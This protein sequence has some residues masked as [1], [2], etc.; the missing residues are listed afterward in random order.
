ML[1][2]EE[3][4]QKYIYSLQVRASS[5]NSNKSNNYSQQFLKLYYLTFMC[6]STSFGRPHAHHQ[7]LNCSNSLWFYRWSVEVAVLLVVVG[8]PY[9]CAPTVKPEAAT[10]VVEL[11]LGVRTPETC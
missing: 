7:E 11:M 1:L 10:A 2:S 4:Q 9:H 6:S 3:K 8:P 5:Y